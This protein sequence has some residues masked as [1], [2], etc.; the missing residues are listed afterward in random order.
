VTQYLI[1]S[2]V[3]LLGV[4]LLASVLLYAT[5][6]LG[7]PTG[8]EHT[9]LIDRLPLD[10]R[11]AVYVVR[12][13]GRVFVLAASE[14]AITKLGELAADEFPRGAGRHVGFGEVL[15]RALG[16]RKPETE[17][18]SSPLEAPSTSQAPTNTNGNV[19]PRTPNDETRA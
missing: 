1:Q 3:T 11:R 17:P 10:A 15:K 19:T 7:R 5:R 13:K 9:E 12:V 18:T 2:S 16:Q 14:A 4:V 6:R 8:P